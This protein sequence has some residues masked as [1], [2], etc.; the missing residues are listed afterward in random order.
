MIKF[1][2]RIDLTVPLPLKNIFE[3]IGGPELNF[4]K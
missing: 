3:V 4:K 2:A 1:L